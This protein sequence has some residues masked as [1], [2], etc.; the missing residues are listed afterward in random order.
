[1]DNKQV[2]AIV[3]EIIYKNNK[4]QAIISYILIGLVMGGLYIYKKI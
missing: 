2:E 4:Q 1:M 3:K